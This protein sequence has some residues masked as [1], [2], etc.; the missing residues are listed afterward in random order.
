MMINYS[1]STNI[2]Y[3]KGKYRL[4]ALKSKSYFETFIHFIVNQTHFISAF[5]FFQLNASFD[6]KISLALTRRRVNIPIY[7]YILAVH[8]TR[9]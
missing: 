3:R 8:F 2:A 7:A 1:C 6:S 4:V 9:L 5:F